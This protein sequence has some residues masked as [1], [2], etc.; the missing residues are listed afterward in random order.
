MNDKYIYLIKRFLRLGFFFCMIFLSSS[1]NELENR[2][3]L[4]GKS[5]KERF[6]KILNQSGAARILSEE[7]MFLKKAQAHTEGE[8]VER[9]SVIEGIHEYFKNPFTCSIIYDQYSLVEKK[10]DKP[11]ITSTKRPFENMQKNSAIK[12]TFTLFEKTAQLGF[13]AYSLYYTIKE[14][15]PFEVSIMKDGVKTTHTFLTEDNVDAISYECTIRFF[16]FHV[17]YKTLESFCDVLAINPNDKEANKT[18]DGK[19]RL[20]IK[21]L[22]WEIMENLTSLKKTVDQSYEGLKGKR[23]IWFQKQA[24]V[25]S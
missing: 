12:K 10:G 9:W 11:A 7:E 15:E 8:L 3:G 24:I 14:G 20:I 23:R 19:G 4:N 22:A 13:D 16:G 21:N 25:N 18:K 6:M 1:C 17:A 2:K 5:L